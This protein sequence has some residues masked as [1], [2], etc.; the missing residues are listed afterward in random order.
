MTLDT[1]VGLAEDSD[2]DA[3]FAMDEEKE[4]NGVTIQ[5]GKLVLKLARVGGSNKTF[6]K[7]AEEAFR[8]YRRM[9]EA[10]V[11]LPEDVSK[12]I[13]FK[14]YSNI[15]KDWNR[16]KDGVPIPCTPDEVVKLFEKR[17]EVFYFVVEE[18]KRAANYRKASAEVDRKN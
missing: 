6:A 18:S 4:L 11:E 14:L 5:F 8:P 12:E 17:P 2:I 15:V 9:M 7:A 3:I 1:K 13:G 16:A 10:G